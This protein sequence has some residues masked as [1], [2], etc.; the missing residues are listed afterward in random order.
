[1]RQV[2]DSELYVPASMRLTERL[3]QFFLY[4]KQFSAYVISSLMLF[5][6]YEPVVPTYPLPLGRL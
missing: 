6:L 2:L 1:V 3:Y 4:K 5:C